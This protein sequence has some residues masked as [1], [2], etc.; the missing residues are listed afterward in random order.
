MFNKELLENIQKQEIF[1]KLA[2]IPS[3]SPKQMQN[4]LR[5]VSAR[6]RGGVKFSPCPKFGYI[7]KISQDKM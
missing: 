5:R 3:P 2:G 4:K 7:P 1:Q 6:A